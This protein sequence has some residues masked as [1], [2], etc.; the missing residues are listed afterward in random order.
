MISSFM[1]YYEVCSKSNTTCATIGAGTSYPFRGPEYTP[2][3]CG[4]CVAS[5]LVF[6]KSLSFSFDHCIVNSPSIYGFWLPIGIFYLWGQERN[7]TTKKMISLFSIVNF[8][9]ICSNIP[10]APA[11]GSYI[12]Q[13]IRYSRACGSYNG[14]LDKGLLLTRVTL[15]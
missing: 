7:F 13:L 5:S 11:Y 1:T 8:P 14:F 12:S 10:A 15:S 6:C 2:V 9:F 4:V 3:C